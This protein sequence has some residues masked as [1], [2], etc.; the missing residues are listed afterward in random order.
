MTAGTQTALET[1]PPTIKRKPKLPRRPRLRDWPMRG[2]RYNIKQ[3][4]GDPPEWVEVVGGEMRRCWN[5]MVGEMRRALRP[6]QD[7][8]R[9]AFE[10]IEDPVERVAKQKEFDQRKREAIKPFKNT[11]HLRAIAQRYKGVLPSDCYYRVADRFM[12]AMQEAPARRSRAFQT[13]GYA[14]FECGLPR[15]KDKDDRSLH[16]PVVFN[17]SA[18]A[19]TTFGDLY[20]D[21]K[22][23]LWRLPEASHFG[24]N[25]QFAL[26]QPQGSGAQ[27][28]PLK[29]LVDLH[30][31]PPMTAIVKGVTLIRYKEISERWKISF[32]LEMPPVAGVQPRA[33]ERVCG[34]DAAG[35]RKLDDRIRLGVLTDNAGYSYEI[36]L[37]MDMSTSLE[38]HQR[39]NR[40][41]KG[42]VDRKLCTW[43]QL[44]E[45]TEKIGQAVEDCKT[46]LR[47]V[48]ESNKEM[49]PEEARQ[50]M[51]GIVK[52]RQRGLIR[53]REQ[54]EGYDAEA[55]ALLDD[56]KAEDDELAHWKRVFELFAGAAKDDAYR[57]IAVWLAQ[58]F[59]RI[60][61]EGD[62]TMMKQMAESVT[63]EYAIK[64]SQRYRQFAGQSFLRLYVRQACQKWGAELQDHK[65]A[66][67][68]R[69]CP[70]CGADVPKSGKLLLTCDEGHKIDQD[71]LASMN[72]LNMIE[73]AASISAAPV[74]IPPDLRRYLRLMTVNEAAIEVV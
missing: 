68:T 56:W 50:S 52:M 19:E 64:A 72:F 74:A 62:R 73:G 32:S 18:G 1:Q 12:K 51:Q 24:G 46:D 49:W 9:T 28:Q 38:R 60:A 48:F 14:P 35:W 11:Q 58:N 42:L 10:G 4:I 7:E 5:D 54:L 53:L 21:G 2:Y 20:N 47:A 34:W 33:G 69:V 3:V 67:S 16:L 41:R 25:C 71:V 15:F 27:W 17:A 22:V 55:C 13:A 43:S 59:S 44:I 36:S 6:I 39:R 66:Y 61:W 40:E 57:K 23:T 31:L 65:A 37:P 45:Q 8:A 30:R 29:L 63:N 26:K 70:E